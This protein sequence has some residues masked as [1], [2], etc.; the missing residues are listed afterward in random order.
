MEFPGILKKYHVEILGVNSRRSVIFR[1]DQ[2]KIMLRGV[3][4]FYG[5]SNSKILLC[6]EFCFKSLKIPDFF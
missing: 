3:T 5:V 2:E 6:P 4:Q 1:G